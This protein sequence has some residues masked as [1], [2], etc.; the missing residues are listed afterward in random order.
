M[1]RVQGED[2][3]H[4]HPPQEPPQ[5]AGA[6]LVRAPGASPDPWP[7]GAQDVRAN[8]QALRLWG[9]LELLVRPRE[10]GPPERA[11]H[12]EQPL[13][14]WRC[15][16][17]RGCLWEGRVRGGHGEALHE[18]HGASDQR[19]EARGGDEHHQVPRA[20]RGLH[21]RPVA[22]DEQV[23]RHVLRGRLAAPV[24]D[25]CHRDERGELRDLLDGDRDHRLRQEPQVPPRLPKGVLQDSGDGV[26]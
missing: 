4:H 22:P 11:R 9:P 24:D 12:P 17:P 10:L 25:R 14:Y 23:C 16:L 5:P 20:P 13:R 3:L 8:V 18:A 6:L 7:H 2:D 1:L 26:P 21:H 15:H 19:Q